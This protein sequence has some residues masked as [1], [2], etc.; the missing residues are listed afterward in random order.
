VI[1]SSGFR[2]LPCRPLHRRDG[3][4]VAQLE[5]RPALQ[6]NR[7]DSGR[8]LRAGERGSLNGVELV[9]QPTQDGGALG[10]FRHLREQ[11]LGDG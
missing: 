9:A 6:L 10:V 1:S 5:G 3:V 2:W 7:V 11:L 8:I 4:R